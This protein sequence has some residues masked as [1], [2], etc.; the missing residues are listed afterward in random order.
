MRKSVILVVV[1]FAVAS[2]MGAFAYNQAVVES[3]QTLKVV[4]TNQALLALKPG[5]GVGNKD[6]TAYVD[7]D[8][9]LK[10]D[11]GRGLGENGF[12]GLQP[13]STYT[14]NKLISIQNK[15]AETVEVTLNLENG[16]AI[17]TVAIANVEGTS[18]NNWFS[19]MEVWSNDNATA[20]DLGPNCTI[21]LQ[22]EV[23]I[24]RDAQLGTFAGTMT[25][26]AVAK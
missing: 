21:D 14:W 8:G 24:P 1:L 23:E 9:I 4:A 2:L 26:D 7:S 11:F 6:K 22:F 18:N 17:S 15:S 19:G 16:V 3:D 10:I 13:G 12:H 20:F 5:D 25:V